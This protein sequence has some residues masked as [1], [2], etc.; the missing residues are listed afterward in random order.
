MIKEL[1]K[2]ANRLDT[3]GL[4][5]EADSIDG[6]IRRIAA[7]PKAERQMY[8]ECSCSICGEKVIQPLG[9]DTC[10]CK[11]CKPGYL[12][13][14]ISDLEDRIERINKKI[15]K[16]NIELKRAIESGDD[17]SISNIKED[18]ENMNL[19]IEEYAGRLERNQ[20][21]LSSLED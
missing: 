17:E 15:D 21:E 9:G 16:K 14:I 18:I 11:V 6:L 10:I 4:K 12:S 19:D 13:D 3:L 8:E 2:I 5:K 20:N 7:R 1:V